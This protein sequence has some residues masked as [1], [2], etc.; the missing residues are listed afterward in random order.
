MGVDNFRV[1]FAPE[2]LYE[3]QRTDPKLFSMDCS[4]YYS[5]VMLV[6][7]CVYIF[8]FF[9]RDATWKGLSQYVNITSGARYSLSGFIKLIT[10]VGDA[11]Y[12]AVELRLSCKNSQTG[13]YR[14]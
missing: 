2:A 14:I 13:T 12:H 7:F 1:C 9:S 5:N 10:L 4:S 8:I 6:L 11:M 3:R